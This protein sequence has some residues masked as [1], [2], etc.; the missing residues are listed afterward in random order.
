[1]DESRLVQRVKEGDRQALDELFACHRDRLLRMVRLRL[2]RRLR[3]RIDPSDVI[4]DTHLEALQ[5]LPEYLRDPKT[6]FF[7]WLRFL[8]GQKLLQLHREHLGI[9][10]RDVRREVQLHPGPGAT[11]AVLAEHL[12]GKH[13]APSRAAMRGEVKVKLREALED[14]DPIDREVLALRHFEQLSNVETAAEL[15]IEDSAASKR[16]VRAIR[17]LKQVL[18]SMPGG[19][20]GLW[21]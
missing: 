19:P 11:S 5:R 13:T 8:T 7:V 12:L 6:P 14:M 9:E 20:E 16:H 15:G 2:D 21:P 18:E 4:Q 1:M 17:K 10:Q 3:G